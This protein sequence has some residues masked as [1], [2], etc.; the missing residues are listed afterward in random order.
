MIKKVILFS[1][2]LLM[3]LNSV[4]AKIIVKDEWARVT[5]SGSGSVYMTIENNGDQ[6]DNLTSAISD[7]AEMTMIHQTVREENIAKMI[8]VMGG[9]DLPKG[10]RIKL[11]PGGYHLMLM[12]IEKNLTLNDRIR[13]TLSFKNNENIEISPIIKIRP[14]KMH[15]HE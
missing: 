7:E 13:I 4:H 11:E 2:I 10:K 3:G 15:K 12:G 8:H 6:D 1:L 5:P 14:P 9:I